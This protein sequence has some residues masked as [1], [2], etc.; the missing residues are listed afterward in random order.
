MSERYEVNL[1]D[2]AQADLGRIRDFIA[3][4]SPDVADSVIDHILAATVSLEF[5]PPRFIQVG[6]SRRE[7]SPVH[8]VVVHPFV[9]YY[10]IDGEKQVVQVL[11]VRHGRQK[12]LQRFP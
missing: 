4:D 1:T 6:R 7:G 2:E 5:M 11:S 3:S 8:A 9:V 10:T 12:R